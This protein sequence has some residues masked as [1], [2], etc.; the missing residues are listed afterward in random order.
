MIMTILTY[1]SIAIGAV[2]F[3]CIYLPVVINLGCFADDIRCKGGKLNKFFHKTI[4]TL[5]VLSVLGII[6]LPFI[7]MSF[8][9]LLFTGVMIALGFFVVYIVGENWR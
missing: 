2:L 8:K 3:F 7:F 6:A 1:I 9:A 4:M 5:I